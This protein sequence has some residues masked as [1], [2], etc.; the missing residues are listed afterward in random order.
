MLAQSSGRASYGYVDPFAS[1]LHVPH[2]ECPNQGSPIVY[3]NLNYRLGPLGF[4][5][6]QEATARGALNLGNKDVLAALTWVQSNIGAFGGDKDKV[7]IFGESAGAIV[8]AE[9]LLNA[10]FDLA[11][12]AVR[13]FAFFKKNPT[14][15]S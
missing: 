12:A 1:D 10:S 9:I 5:Q 4:P 11:R 3:V 2:T 14:L 7:T 13:I 6:G 8:N 15:T